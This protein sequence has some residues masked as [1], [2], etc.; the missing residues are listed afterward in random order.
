M[1]RQCREGKKGNVMTEGEKSL[2]EESIL[3]SFEAK[4]W[5]QEPRDVGNL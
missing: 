1:K 4:G 5:S 2:E 3:I